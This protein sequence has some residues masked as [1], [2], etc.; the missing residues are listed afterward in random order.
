[1]QANARAVRLAEVERLAHTAEQHRARPRDV[2][3]D[4][5]RAREVVAAAAGQHAERAPS[6]QR[7]RERADEPV[8][9]ERDHELALLGGVARDVCRVGQVTRLDDPVRGTG[10]AQLALDLRQQAQGL[11]PRGR[12]VH[13]NREL[14]RRRSRPPRKVVRPGPGRS[15]G[16]RLEALARETLSRSLAAGV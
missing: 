10:G 6:A 15:G 12:R 2:L 7:A 1:M 16:D 9:A 5:D 14:A 4:A 8:A 11:A 3:G 13:Q